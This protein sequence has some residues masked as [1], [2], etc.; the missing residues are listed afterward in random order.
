M[1]KTIMIILMMSITL[2]IMM[3]LKII[4]LIVN[5]N[6]DGDDLM[7]ET[8]NCKKRIIEQYYG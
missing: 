7:A 2:V 3:V 8:F 4:I 1:V 5:G 6:I